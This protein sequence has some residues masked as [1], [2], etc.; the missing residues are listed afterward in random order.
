[1]LREDKRQ[2]HLLSCV[3]QWLSLTDSWSLKARAGRSTLI[4]PPPGSAASPPWLGGSRAGCRSPCSRRS[5]GNS[6]A[7]GTRQPTFHPPRRASCSLPLPST[8]SKAQAK[9][10]RVS[11]LNCCSGSPGTSREESQS[12]LLTPPSPWHPCLS[13]A[14]EVH[15][16]PCTRQSL[17]KPSPPAHAT[18]F[19]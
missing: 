11:Q 10:M 17:P 2:K 18:S 14:S 12:L 15:P 5:R 1:M 16:K 13:P 4:C 7:Q 6:S 19:P 8:G 3:H 9:P